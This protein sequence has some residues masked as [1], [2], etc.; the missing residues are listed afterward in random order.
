MGNVIEV[1][2]SK[3]IPLNS[4]QR[5]ERQEP[6]RYYGA[7]GIMDY[8]DEFLFDGVYVLIA[9]DGSVVDVDGQP[10]VQYVWGQ[11][12]VSNHAHVLRGKCEIRNEHLYLLLRQLNVTAF[13]TGAVQPKL[14]Q[15]NLK[16]IAIVLPGESVCAAFAGQIE[17]LC[18]STRSNSHEIESLVTQR[19]ALL[20][21]L[22]SGEVRV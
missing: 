16:A 7:A 12:W 8:V 13:V 2:D 4:R 9:E 20:P 5:A 18:E 22:E 14:S 1:H 10:V 11:F 17:P 15:K 19:D 21:R 6:F 3:R